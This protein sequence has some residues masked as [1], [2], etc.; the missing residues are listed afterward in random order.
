MHTDG[1]KKRAEALLSGRRDS[2]PR[3]RPWQGRA[4]PTELLPLVNALCQIFK[5][6]QAVLY[7]PIIIGRA[8]PARL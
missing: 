6:Y 5:N 7:L 3:P 8:T 1:N 4:L 2:N